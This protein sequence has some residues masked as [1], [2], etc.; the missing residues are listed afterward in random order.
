MSRTV[1][2]RNR[3]YGICICRLVRSNP[4][5][6]IYIY[7]QKVHW[8]FANLVCVCVWE[9]EQAGYKLTVIQHETNGE[10]SFRTENATMKLFWQA[11]NHQMLE[12]PIAYHVGHPLNYTLQ[13]FEISAPGFYH[14]RKEII[15]KDG[16]WLK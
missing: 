9:R 14:T 3:L 4:N 15:A 2:K 6:Y 11:S 5:M 16:H 1:A 7:L 8:K 13:T 12:V 10:N